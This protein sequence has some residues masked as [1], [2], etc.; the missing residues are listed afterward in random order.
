M[1]NAYIHLPVPWWKYGVI[2]RH[3]NKILGLQ[4]YFYQVKRTQTY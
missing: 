1:T 3:I 2:N 4:K